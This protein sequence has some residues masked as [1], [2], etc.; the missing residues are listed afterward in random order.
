MRFDVGTAESR[1]EPG[2]ADDPVVVNDAQAMRVHILDADRQ[3]HLRFGTE[4]ALMLFGPGVEAIDKRNDQRPE[5]RA[6]SL[7]PLLRSCGNAVGA[8][9]SIGLEILLAV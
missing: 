6:L 5:L 2:R 4:I 1:L 9:P 8:H 7:R 3:H